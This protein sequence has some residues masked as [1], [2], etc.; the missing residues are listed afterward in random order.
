MTS[1]FQ[2]NGKLAERCQKW[3]EKVNVSGFGFECRRT[4]K[5]LSYDDREW[6]RAAVR[7][8]EPEEIEA[9]DEGETTMDRAEPKFYS[10][11]SFHVSNWKYFH[12]AAASHRFFVLQ[13]LLAPRGIVCG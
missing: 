4:E 12:D 13:E 5:N 6:F 7:V 10:K 9:S 11:D 2:E 3:V 1:L 8:E